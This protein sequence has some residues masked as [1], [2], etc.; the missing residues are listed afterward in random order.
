[1]KH[2]TSLSNAEIS[3]QFSNSRDGGFYYDTSVIESA[4]SRFQAQSDEGQI[5]DII[6]WIGDEVI[7]FE[8]LHEYFSDLEKYLPEIEDLI[9]AKTFRIMVHF[10]TDE[11][12]EADVLEFLIR[13]Y[14]EQIS[15][16]LIDLNY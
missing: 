13:V 14:K 7:A 4:W 9:E 5:D 1:M 8:L 15:E 10:F 11:L 16:K 3:H 6:D 12:K 2:L